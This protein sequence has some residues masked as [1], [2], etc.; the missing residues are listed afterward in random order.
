MR[1]DYSHFKKQIYNYCDE[2]AGEKVLFYAFINLWDEKYPVIKK[3]LIGVTE[4]IIRELIKGNILTEIEKPGGL[5]TPCAY[6]KIN[7]HEDLIKKNENLK[8]KMKLL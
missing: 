3:D 8:K 5:D 4:K 2:N 7:S 1:Q 6:Y